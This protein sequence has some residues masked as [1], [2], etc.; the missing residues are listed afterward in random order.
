MSKDKEPDWNRVPAPYAVPFRASAQMVHN[1]RRKHQL[2]NYNI[3]A[4]WPEADLLVYN[5]PLPA[6]DLLQVGEIQALPHDNDVHSLSEAGSLLNVEPSDNEV[7]MN[8]EQ[9]T[10]QM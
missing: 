7:P 5:Q 3:N 8:L 6:R 2:P 4:D 10:S 1:K 9:D